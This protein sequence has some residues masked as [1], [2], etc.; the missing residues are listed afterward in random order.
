MGSDWQARRRATLRV[1]R[2]RVAGDRRNRFGVG[3]ITGRVH[4]NWQHDRGARFAHRNA[5]SRR[6][7]LDRGRVQVGQIVTVLLWLFILGTG[8][9]WAQ[10]IGI[11]TEAGSMTASR[12]NHTA[13]LLQDGRVL[14]AGG[15]TFVP[16]ERRARL[17]RSAELY[18]PSTGAFAAI[19]ELTEPRAYHT[20]TL[21][22]DGRVL[23]TGGQTFNQF[24]RGAVGSAEIY[25][26][27][28]GKFTATGPMVA[29]RLYHTAVLLGNGKVL[30][31]SGA[32]WRNSNTAI[33]LRA[34]LY[35]P[36]S[37]TFA[38]T[39]TPVS[40]NPPTGDDFVSPTATLLQDGR[41]LVTWTS[42]LAEL[43]DPRAGTFSPTGSMIAGRAYEGGTQTLL[44]NG[45]VLVAGGADSG[46]IDSAE[47]YEPSTGTFRLT[48]KMTTRR[49]RHTATLLRDGTVLTTGGNQEGWGA[50]DRSDQYDPNSGSF[51]ARASLAT[52]RYL[53]TATQLKDGKILIAGGIVGEL[54]TTTSAA[55]Y[56]PAGLAAPVPVFPLD[57]RV[58]ENL[59]PRLQVHNVGIIGG[60]GPVTY[61]FEW[62]DRPDF[63]PGRRTGFKDNA[64]EGGGG[65]TAHEITED[66]ASNTLHYWRARATGTQ[67][68][69]GT[70][71]TVTSAYSQVRS[72]TTP[73]LG[74]ITGTN[75]P[76]M[77]PVSGTRA[78]PSSAVAKPPFD[79]LTLAQD[80]PNIDPDLAAQPSNLVATASGS[81]VV[82]T[83]IGPPGA[84]PVRYAISGGTAPHTSTLPVIV[85]ADAS[86]RYTIP[87]LLPGSYY[88]TVF[89]ILADGLSPRSDEAAVVVSGS[90]SASGPPSGALAVIEGGYITATWTPSP[91]V[92]TLY[93]V[94]IGRGPGQADVAVLTTTKPSVTYRGDDAAAYYLRVRAVYGAMVSAPS[95]EVSVSAA[96][97]ICAGAPLGPVLLPVSTTN[98]ETTIG[99]LPAGGGRADHY[100]VDITGAAGPMSMSSVGT[101]TSLTAALKPGAY[102]IRVTAIN[103]CGVSLAS[104]SITFTQPDSGTGAM[105]RPSTP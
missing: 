37:G 35:D 94:E 36:T 85:T 7:G 89:A 47:V 62:S 8:K 90:Q 6:Q 48:G 45:T 33:D 84:T 61:R 86:N 70:E 29:A 28:S 30:I 99:W 59:R 103:T 20:A 13:T 57:G 4:G 68:V 74:V 50:L 10:S 105:A 12:A 24:D 18:D 71:V 72:F 39:G 67:M 52:P 42:A 46:A 16:E 101:S 60:V 80:K 9:V 65:D 82:L 97:A 55:L 5:A 77:A 15:Y 11:F 34:E 32:E 95:N 96:P 54:S 14:I 104:N 51:W 17:L 64:P 63:Q 44:A 22:P 91:K 93:D 100:R 43:Y 66:L 73:P 25:D 76:L 56:I 2:A 40:V 31:I 53:H 79:S 87:S 83:W 21:L 41:V 3:A 81:G 58:T 88:F 23:I 69:D 98:G 19:G 27:N 49:Y 38:A 75:V 26:P 78:A 102:T 92:G 1:G